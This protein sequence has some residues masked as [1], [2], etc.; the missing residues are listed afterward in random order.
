MSFNEP[1]GDCRVCS[2]LYSYGHL[3]APECHH[4]GGICLAALKIM[5]ARRE[6]AINDGRASVPKAPHHDKCDICGGNRVDYV[7]EKGCLPF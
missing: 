7:C 4:D 1:D 6:E 2:F 3:D 5:D